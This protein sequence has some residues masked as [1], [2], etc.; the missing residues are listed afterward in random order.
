LVDT[1]QV[2]DTFMGHCNPWGGAWALQI[3]PIHW[4]ATMTPWD[5]S[6]C[7]QHV[8]HVG[9]C[10]PFA[11]TLEES[12]ADSYILTA[13]YVVTAFLLLPLA[14]MDLTENV[15]YQILGF[16]ILLVT[17]VQFIVTF[18]LQS[19][20]ETSRLSWWGHDY[21]NLLGVILFNYALVIT[22]PAWLYEKESHVDIPTVMHGSTITST[23]LYIAIG[24]LGCLAMPDVSDNFLESIMS[25]AL[26]LPTQIGSSIFAF[27]IVGLNIPLFSILARLSLTGGGNENRD[28]SIGNQFCSVPV[29]NILSVYLPFGF[30]WLFYQG[31]MVTI[32]LS[33]GGMI[34]TSLVSFL[35]PLALALYVVT[36]KFEDFKG[37]VKVYPWHLNDILSSKESQIH[38]LR[39]LLCMSIVLVATAI[40][41]NIFPVRDLADDIEQEVAINDN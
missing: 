32:L 10:I 22:V 31:S 16:F 5:P 1:A 15:Q 23:V 19:N 40:A 36:N 2:L 13:G 12:D 34:F 41:G 9:G 25:G 30:S 18:T 14:L 35:L 27:F 20:I 39:V 8:L 28:N 4:H 26:G 17:S 33:W 38:A 29:A 6:S 3:D 37:S 7:S 21:D 24:I 11:N